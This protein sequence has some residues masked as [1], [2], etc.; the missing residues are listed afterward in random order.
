MLDRGSLVVGDAGVVAVVDGREVGD[1]EQ[2]GELVVV[3]G[4]AQVGRDGP[5]VFLPGEIDG[6]V[7]GDDHARDEHALAD[8][9]A[10][11]LKRLDVRRFC[12]EM[13]RDQP[14]SS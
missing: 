5:S 8:G 6:V 1:A 3:D 4:D 9:V 11:H 14:S 10:L 2:A 13:T 12:R 7:A